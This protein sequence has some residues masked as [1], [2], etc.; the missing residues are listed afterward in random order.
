[1]CQL[2][3]KHIQLTLVKTTFMIIFSGILLLRTVAKNC[4]CNG[5]LQ[6][7]QPGFVFPRSII[8]LSSFSISNPLFILIP[9]LLK[10]RIFSNPPVYYDPPPFIWHLR[11]VRKMNGFFLNFSSLCPNYLQKYKNRCEKITIDIISQ[12]HHNHYHHHQHHYHHHHH[13]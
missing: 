7:S 9:C 11:L 4:C 3:S 8:I 13:N 6:K 10:F 12:H 5:S 1:M 2:T